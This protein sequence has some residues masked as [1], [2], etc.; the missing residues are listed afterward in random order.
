MIT[1][2][3]K[4]GAELQ[5]GDFPFCPH[6]RGTAVPFRDDIPGG[7]VC[8]NYGPN[9]IT[10]YSHTKRREYMKAN[11]LQEKEKFCPM[12][13]TD[14]DPAGIPNPKG[15]V[16]PQTL[17]NGI[18]L[19]TRQQKIQEFDGIKS[20]VLRNLTTEVVDDAEEVRRVTH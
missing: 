14:I 9:P 12:P 15:F 2:C 19:I 3:E 7:L 8:E 5:M 10:F 17:A 4:C 6:G 20:G 13:G 16:D 11:G 1:V 18:A